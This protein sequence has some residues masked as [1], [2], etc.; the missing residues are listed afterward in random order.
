MNKSFCIMLFSVIFLAACSEH[1]PSGEQLMENPTIIEVNTVQDLDKIF[2]DQQY[3]IERWQSGVREVP[4]LTFDGVGADWKVAA[5]NMTVNKKKG[6]FFRMMLPLILISNENIL[7][8]RAVVESAKVDDEALIKLAVKYRVIKEEAPLNEKQKETLL[9]RV[10]IIPPSLALAQ[11]AEESSWG[12]SRFADEG[13]A[14]F[15]Q[16]DFSGNGI[17]PK[18]QR[19]EL[20]NYGIARFDSPLD[21]VEGYML[22]I[23]T[24][25]AYKAL[26]D[27]RAEK[28]AKNEAF[29]GTLLAGT[30][31]KYSERGE[32]YIKGLRSLISYNKLSPADEAYLAD[33]KVIHILHP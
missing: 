33:K 22:N 2:A 1:T 21:S 10:N 20:G 15:G 18:Q 4:R 26:R 28:V 27:L 25:S 12:T 17:K 30:L 6:I 32:E 19:T 24:T 5:D 31:T 14:F 13:N 29:S 16:W 11:A 7:Q 9:N 23:N 8:E 3:T